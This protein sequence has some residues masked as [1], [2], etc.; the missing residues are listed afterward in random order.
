MK[1]AGCD[2]S[3]AVV[4]YEV[5]GAVSADNNSVAFALGHIDAA[6]IGRHLYGK[7][8]SFKGKVSKFMLGRGAFPYEKNVGFSMLAK[9]LEEE[10]F[11]A[12]APVIADVEQYCKEI[13]LPAGYIVA[14]DP[15][16]CAWALGHGKRVIPVTNA[17]MADVM[18]SFCMTAKIRMP[19]DISQENFC[20]ALLSAIE[21]PA[22]T[23]INVF[24]DFKI[25]Q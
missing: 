24:S 15:Y 1:A 19:L 2:A 9:S 6:D 23:D 12:E 3:V 11:D 17:D 20:E 10:G 18:A 5:D 25:S 16:L 14:D 13:L 7:S 22:H 4:N 8:E 21:Y